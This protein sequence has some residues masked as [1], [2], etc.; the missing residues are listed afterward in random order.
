MSLYDSDLRWVKTVHAASGV[1]AVPRTMFWSDYFC[2]STTPLDI[3]GAFATTAPLRCD[4]LTLAQKH[5]LARASVHCLRLIEHGKR[6]VPVPTVCDIDVRW[7]RVI[8]A[9]LSS[10]GIPRTLPASDHL[11]IVAA[12]YGLPGAFVP[13][14]DPRP[15]V[16]AKRCVVTL[17]DADIAHLKSGLKRDPSRYLRHMARVKLQSLVTVAP[18]VPMYNFDWRRVKTLHIA[19]GVPGI[20]RTLLTSDH[21]CVIATSYGLPSTQ[22]LDPAQTALVPFS[23][24]RS[25]S[26]E[27]GPVVR[28]KR[29]VV[30]FTDVDAARTH[31]VVAP[32]M[33][34]PEYPRF[35]LAA[36]WVR[37]ILGVPRSLFP[38][39]HLE[40]IAAEFAVSRATIEVCPSLS[41][42]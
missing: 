32:S 16:E 14:S 8:Q 30:T 13:S 18:L 40:V 19:I 34:Y 17:T 1:L 15:V 24:M 6:E 42:D 26:A 4:T 27:L 9:A 39:G 21:F 31:A 38:L 41:A 20:P 22:A 23:K 7:A 10:L 35:K 11:P 5:V 36:R 12:T 37:T 2:T 29:S 3:A 28:V 25:L 33:V